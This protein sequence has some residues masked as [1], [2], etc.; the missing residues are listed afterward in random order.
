MS[1]IDFLLVAR[2]RAGIEVDTVRIDQPF[3]RATEIALARTMY[4]RVGTKAS[5]TGATSAIVAFARQCDRGRTEACREGAHARLGVV[6]QL[7][8]VRRR[9][10]TLDAYGCNASRTSIHSRYRSS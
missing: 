6:N 3:N 9:T 5:R 8:W 10:T 2:D 1:Y 7:H 4:D